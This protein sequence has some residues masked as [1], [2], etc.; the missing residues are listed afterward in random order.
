MADKKVAKTPR[1]KGE[2]HMRHTA[3]S[4][5]MDLKT[6]FALSLVMYV[7]FVVKQKLKI[8]DAFPYIM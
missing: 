5:I 6:T 4:L 7:I 8:K 3:R 2:F 1:G